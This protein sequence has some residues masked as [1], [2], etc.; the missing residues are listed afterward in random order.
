M[1]QDF[2]WLYNELFDRHP[3]VFW[4]FR[5]NCINKFFKLLCIAL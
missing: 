4:M 1:K 2:F 3:S 5:N